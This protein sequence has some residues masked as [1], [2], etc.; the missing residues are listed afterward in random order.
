MVKNKKKSEQEK[1]LGWMYLFTWAMLIVFGIVQKRVFDRPDLMVFFHL[2]AAVFLVLG[3]N[4]LSIEV[5][6]ARRRE[7]ME[8]RRQMN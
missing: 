6:V 3:F 1:R 5:R 4:K 8:M 7:L 2:P